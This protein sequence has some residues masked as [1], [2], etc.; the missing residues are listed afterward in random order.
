MGGREKSDGKTAKCRGT[1]AE[2]VSHAPISILATRQSRIELATTALQRPLQTRRSKGT[3]EQGGRG[4]ARGNLTRLPRPV[5]S[6]RPRNDRLDRCLLSRALCPYPTICRLWV[7]RSSV[8]SRVARRLPGRH[9][10]VAASRCAAGL[11][12]LWGAVPREDRHLGALKVVFC[13]QAQAGHFGRLVGTATPLRGHRRPGPVRAS[14]HLSRVLVGAGVTPA[15]HSHGPAPLAAVVVGDRR[16]AHGR[17]NSDRAV[18]RPCSRLIRPQGPQPR[19]AVWRACPHKS[20]A[21]GCCWFSGRFRRLGGSVK[22]TEAGKYVPNSRSQS[23]RPHPVPL[24]RLCAAVLS[25]NVLT[26][27]HLGCGCRPRSPYTTLPA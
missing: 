17:V 1:K 19:T 2:D 27:R 11:D 7:A 10:L 5:S 21:V 23:G 16:C 15:V 13:P 22:A 4:W 18:H 3:S 25:T 24:A 9:S 8:G 12:F 6:W 20:H 14:A 26:L